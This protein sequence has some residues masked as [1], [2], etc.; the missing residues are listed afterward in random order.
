MK[1]G[2]MQP[3]FFPYI[4]YFQLIANTNRWVF[5]DV[6]QYNK[7]SWMNRNRILHPTKMDG[8]QY[9]YV[10]IQNHKKGTLIKDVKINNDIKWQQEIIGKLTVYK[11]M[12]AHF[13][14]QTLD[15]I[16][17]ILNHSYT[18]FIDLSVRSVKLICQYIGFDFEYDIASELKIDRNLVSVPDDWALIITK[19][20]G[21]NIYINPPAGVS[22]FDEHKYENNDLKLLFLKA[23][24][25]PYKQ[26]KRKDFVPGLSIIDLLM[27]NRTDEIKDMLENDFKLLS[28]NQLLKDQAI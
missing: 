13:Y 1:V 8:F 20:L 17:S 16:S 22:I 9:I 14:D 2:I 28:K 12:R 5:F 7:R 27:F 25:S 26:S 11:R 21:G 19:K 18:S 24:L 3:Y 23:K 4:G 10:P 15:L 6:V